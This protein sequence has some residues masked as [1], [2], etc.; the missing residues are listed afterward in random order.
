MA[1]AQRVGLQAAGRGHWLVGEGERK[2]ELSQGGPSPL[3]A[4][5]EAKRPRDDA[6]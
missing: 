2:A 4:G 3:D 6:W 1:P 5:S